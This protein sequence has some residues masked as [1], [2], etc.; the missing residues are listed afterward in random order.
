MSDFPTARWHNPTITPDGYEAGGV[1]KSVTT[2]VWSS[3]VW[4]SANRAIYA[5][6]RI[7]APYLVQRVFWANGATVGN[8]TAD[9]GVYTPGGARLFS[10]G[11]TTTAEANI[12][13]SVAITP[14][15][16]VPGPYYMALSLSSASDT[17]LSKVPIARNLIMMGYAQQGSVATLPATFTLA[18]L[19]AGYVPL[20]GI[21]SSTVI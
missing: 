15:L 21:T 11:P 3:G 7:W 9:C 1:L 16:L 13:Q 17:I 8:G 2:V 5:P 12:V 10:A 6:F 20:F 18:S 4:P 19:A 14:F